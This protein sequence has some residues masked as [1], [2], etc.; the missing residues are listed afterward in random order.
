M[1]V[2]VK[3]FLNVRVG[4]PSVNAPCY[5]YLAPG[6]EIEIDGHLYNGDTFESIS[7]WLKDEANNY[8]WSGGT[9]FTGDAFEILKHS[10]TPTSPKKIF[11]WFNKLNIEQ[12]WNTYREKGDAV[13]IAVLDTGS[14]EAMEDVKNGIASR[15]IFIDNTNYPG[16]EII[17]ND[18]SNDGHGTRCASLIGSRNNL[19][20]FIGI[21]PECKLITGKISINREMRNFN[22][23]IDGIIWAIEQGADIISISYAI[24]LEP[25]EVD[26]F[27]KKFNDAIKNKNVLV[28]AATGNS[29]NI[30]ETA[31]RYPASFD[32]CIS[33]G[34]VD[35]NGIPSSMNILNNKTI[36]HA[37]G[38][39]IESF[40]HNTT[41]DPQSGTSFS[42]P[43]VAAIAG[44]AVSHIK[45]HNHNLWNCK[46]V[47]NQLYQTADPIEGHPTKK[48]VN[49]INLLK[50]FHNLS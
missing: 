11:S 38:I 26:H 50:K 20:W 2:L 35:E 21:A 18:Q 7:T 42:T 15:K 9:N 1:K 48:V 47:L 30:Q 28:F 5:Q 36:I 34:A 23:I 46:D 16:I 3:H 10:I 31:A 22:F 4:K 45:K 39:N 32:D 8:Y 19:S 43:I 25:Q 17:G 13:T 24:E 14:N 29:G 37:P 12:A 44:L 49:A 27:N 41:P 40:G 6:S 33:V